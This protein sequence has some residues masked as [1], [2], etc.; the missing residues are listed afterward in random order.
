MKNKKKK[1][2][3]EG[4]YNAIIV[5]LSLHSPVM[6]SVSAPNLNTCAFFIRLVS[7]LIVGLSYGARNVPSF[8]RHMMQNAFIDSHI[9]PLRRSPSLPHDILARFG[10]WFCA[11]VVPGIS[12]SSLHAARGDK[13]F[14]SE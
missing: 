14:R 8:T 12:R 11:A 9:I 10:K 5:S 2:R 3:K 7:V 1:R 13:D 4:S 6:K